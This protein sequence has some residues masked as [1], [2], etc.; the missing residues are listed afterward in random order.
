MSPGALHL[1]GEQSGGEAS[2]SPPGGD[3]SSLGAQRSAGAD[4]ARLWEPWALLAPSDCC[5]WPRGCSALPPHVSAPLAPHP[6]LRGLHVPSQPGKAAAPGTCAGRLLE[7]GP[8]C[9][10]QP[11][12]PQGC[13]ARGGRAAWAGEVCWEL[14]GNLFPVLHRYMELTGAKGWL[15]AASS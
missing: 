8:P 6:R 12:P 14:L 10:R 3:R 4:P 1:I 15:L 5:S 11:V 2:L 9:R 13:P 7:P